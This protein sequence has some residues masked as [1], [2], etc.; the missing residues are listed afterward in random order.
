MEETRLLGSGALIEVAGILVKHRRQYAAADHDI[1]ESA[2]VGCAVTL[3]KSCEA[4]PVVRAGAVSLI[5]SCEEGIRA[6]GG[7]IG[8]S[9]PCQ[10]IL[11]LG[12]HRNELAV[13]GD[14]KIRNEAETD[15]A[16]TAT[17]SWMGGSSSVCPGASARSCDFHSPNPSA[18]TAT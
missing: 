6:E 16:T 4:L 9:V 13:V 18:F 17:E 8:S 12:G 5:D 3:A 1:G 11:Q 14:V 2:G 7:G 10:P 15:V